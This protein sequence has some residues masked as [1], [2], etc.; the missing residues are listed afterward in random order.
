MAK[1]GIRGL[2]RVAAREWGRFGIRVNVICPFAGSPSATS[3]NETHPKAAEAILRNTPLGRMGDCEDDVGR[4]VAALVSD[5][6]DYL[7]GAT[8]MIDGG[9]TF[10]R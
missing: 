8:L 9:L 5:D 1:E 2:S 10:L 7:T 4:A 3:F 6:M